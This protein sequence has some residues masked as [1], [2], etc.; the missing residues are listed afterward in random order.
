MIYLALS[1]LASSLIYVVF[2]L[3][4]KFNIQILQALIFNYITAFLIGLGTQSNQFEVA[5]IISK[6]WFIGSLVLGFMFILVFSLMAKTTQVLG[7]SVVSVASKMSVAVPVGFVIWYYQEALTLFKIIGIALALVSVLLVSLKKKTNLAFN[8]KSFL[9]PI[10]VFVGSGVIETSLKFLEQ[11]YVSKAD[12][13]NFSLVI[14]FFA[15]CFGLVFLFL[16]SLKKENKFNFL[17]KEILGGIVLGIP[18]FYSIY[19]FIS[20]LK[21]EVLPSSLLFVLNNV[22]IV[23]FSTLLGVFIFK[24]RLTLKN[25]LGIALA[26]ASIALLYFGIDIL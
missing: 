11:D 24:E 18:N 4:G 17:P 12:V 20:A 19:F 22:S 14:F 23:V 8:L 9:L 3:L 13:G 6:Q 21:S 2:K 16:K 15:A 10:L 26:A 1:I 7:M 25:W 5:T